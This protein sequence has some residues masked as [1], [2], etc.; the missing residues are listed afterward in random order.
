MVEVL[1]G[2]AI[3]LAIAFAIRA[4]VWTKNNMLDLSHQYR[5][6]F[7]EAAEKIAQWENISD[8]RLNRISALSALLK[9]R[10]VQFLVVKALKE[11]AAGDYGKPIV[12]P[13]K[14]SPEKQTLWHH[15]FFYWLIAA[16]ARGTVIGV[17]AMLQLAKFVDPEQTS[18]KTE[19]AVL[20]H[21][22]RRHPKLFR[23]A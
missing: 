2:G 6:K 3:G 13:D 7:F 5:G 11:V 23:T 16:C 21:E 10:K 8:G 1:V 15:M 19:S 14:L 22:L 12:Y 17:Y 9:N 18:A 4:V 20:R